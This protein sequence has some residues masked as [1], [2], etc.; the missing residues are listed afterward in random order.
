[1]K[2]AISFLLVTGLAVSGAV[3]QQAAGNNTATVATARKAPESVAQKTKEATDRINTQAKLSMDQ[4]NKVYSVLNDYYS[5]VGPI[6]K[7]DN[8]ANSAE[9]KSK[10]DALK[11]EVFN[12][13]QTILSTDQVNT[14]KGMFNAPSGK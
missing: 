12:K 8:G 7:A 1:M 10:I 2:K 6:K 9:T 4:Y 11:N 3:A 5:K 13:L 14:V